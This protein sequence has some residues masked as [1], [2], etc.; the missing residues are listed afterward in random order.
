MEC[1]SCFRN[2]LIL[3]CLASVSA[4]LYYSWRHK[5]SLEED[6]SLGEFEIPYLRLGLVALAAFV[7]GTFVERKLKYK[8]VQRS[9]MKLNTPAM[10]VSVIRDIV[11]RFPEQDIFLDFGGFM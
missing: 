9:D 8:V 1:S 7:L 2:P 11:H 4:Y 3:A 10:N 6:P 5:K